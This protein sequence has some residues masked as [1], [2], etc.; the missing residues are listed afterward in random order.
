MKKT[1]KRRQQRDC[2]ITETIDTI[3]KAAA[4]AM[5]TYRAVEPLV[6][7]VIKNRGKTK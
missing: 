3:E 4:T 1:K 7:A 6:K 2:K 5:K